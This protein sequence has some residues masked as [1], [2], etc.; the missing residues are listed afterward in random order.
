M[1]LQSYTYK[2]LEDDNFMNSIYNK[3]TPI[4]ACR[5]IFYRLL[6]YT[7]LKEV[8]VIIIVQNLITEKLYIYECTAAYRPHK[9]VISDTLTIIRKWEINVLKLNSKC[10]IA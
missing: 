6:R 3:H 1:V 8:K 2:L 4:A 10:F 9:K 7:E 5:S